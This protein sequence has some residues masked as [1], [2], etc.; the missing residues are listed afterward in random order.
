MSVPGKCIFC[1]GKGL[2]KEHVFPAWMRPLL[3]GYVEASEVPN[4]SQMQTFGGLSV[5][6]T[7]TSRG[8]NNQG[9]IF[10]KRLRVVCR[11]CNNGWMSQQEKETKSLL[12]A[13]IEGRSASLGYDEQCRLALWCALRAGIFERD[14][15]ERAA[16]TPHQYR[17]IYEHRTLP[18]GWKVFAASYGGLEW[19]VRMFHLGGK[20]LNIADQS[21]PSVPNTHL[22]AMGMG[23][24]VCA[25]VGS[26]ATNAPHVIA[27]LSP[28]RMQQIWPFEQS[29]G[30]PSLPEVDDNTLDHIAYATPVVM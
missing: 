1:G 6:G 28:I 26:T 16:I 8:W 9:Y 12:T 7:P 18:D 22:T 14:D 23:K 10:N 29:L 20:V 19:A 15:P 2:T 21:M 25:V 17:Y 3:Q 11:S 13:M 27:Q 30:W 4:Y 24:I 5:P